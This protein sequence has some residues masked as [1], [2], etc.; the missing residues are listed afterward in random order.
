MFL[1][2]K[3][4]L[5]SFTRRESDRRLIFNV[6]NLE[7]EEIIEKRDNYFKKA[8][9]LSD[10][11]QIIISWSFVVF[12]SKYFLSKY[13]HY[14]DHFNPFYQ[15]AISMCFMYCTAAAVYLTINTIWT[16][17]L[18]QADEIGRTR[19]RF[20]RDLIYFMGLMVA[21]SLYFGLYL[22]VSDIA[23]STLKSTTATSLVE[24]GKPAGE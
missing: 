4:A 12:A 16:I 23:E 20:G 8:K 10:F 14:A 3:Q 9:T 18:Y 17:L 7:K 22:L 1:K 15:I 11:V 21:G 19:S 5:L 6:V 2:I 24:S 13:F